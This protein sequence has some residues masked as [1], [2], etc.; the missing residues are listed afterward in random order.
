[1]ELGHIR[2]TPRA[3]LF[4]TATSVVVDSVAAAVV[5]TRTFA[6]DRLNSPY[7]R[8]EQSPAS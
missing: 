2:Y 4:L 3:E 8:S 6:E 7:L 5:R 1:M